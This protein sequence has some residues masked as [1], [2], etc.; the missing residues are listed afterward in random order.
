MFF[1]RFPEVSP[2]NRA[3]RPGPS[4]EQPVLS[5]PQKSI[6]HNLPP[7]LTP[8]QGDFANGGTQPS[9]FSAPLSSNRRDYKTNDDRIIGDGDSAEGAN[10]MTYRRALG[11]AVVRTFQNLVIPSEN[12]ESG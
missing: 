6:L 4:S 3:S 8:A 12:D 9:P 10:A 11:F 5:H 1:K 7:T 2:E